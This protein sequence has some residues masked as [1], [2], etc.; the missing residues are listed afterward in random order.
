MSE[1]VTFL[2]LALKAKDATVEI[3]NAIRDG[4]SVDLDAFI[5]KHLG[6]NARRRYERK[7]AVL[8]ATGGVQ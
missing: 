6:A 4:Q 2:T 1:L 3:A 7:I 8:R 5:K